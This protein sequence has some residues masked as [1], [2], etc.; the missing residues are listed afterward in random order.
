MNLLEH[1]RAA[2][3]QEVK[4]G[5]Q[6]TIPV[7]KDVLDKA[8]C[9]QV[10]ILLTP[11]KP[12]P[13]DWLGDLSGKQVLCLASGGGQQGPILA[14]AGARVTVFDN[15]DQQLLRDATLSENYDLKI[16]TVQGNMQDLSAFEDRIFDLIVHPVSNCFIDAIQP[17]WQE[18][19]R[20]LKPHGSLLSG[21]TNPLIYMIDWETAEQTRRCEL[22]HAIPYSDIL[23]LSPEVKAKYIQEKTAFEFGHSLSEQIQG[24]IAA[25]FLI[26][27][28]YEDRGE[29]LLDQITDSFIATKA[30]KY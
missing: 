28:F 24:Q 11:Y 22:K 9:G 14:A 10:T 19:F 16:K 2:W 15:S 21:F 12:V 30:V 20:V 27:G 4:K 5:N 23:S 6:W 25:G 29:P 17:V 13:K 26:A 8:A 1:N 7:T 3:N 18:C